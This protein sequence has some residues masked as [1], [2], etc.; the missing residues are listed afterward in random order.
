MYFKSCT[1]KR[2]TTMLPVHACHCFLYLDYENLIEA[3]YLFSKNNCLPA[4]AGKRNVLH[5]AVFYQLRDEC[6]MSF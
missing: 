5:S 6:R 1:A 2:V 3:W 4:L